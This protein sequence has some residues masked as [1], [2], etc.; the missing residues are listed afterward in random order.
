MSHINSSS[1]SSVYIIGEIGQNHNGSIHIA[2]SI[3]DVVHSVNSQLQR[4]TGDSSIIGFNSIKTTLRDLEYENTNSFNAKPYESVH[5]FGKTYLD[6]RKALEL[7]IDDHAIIAEYARS[8]D[9]D[10]VVTLCAPSCLN[11]LD[12]VTPAYLK[13]A[14]RDL[15]NIPLIR[16]LA[17]TKIPMIISTGMANIEDIDSALEA[18]THYHSSV[19]IL[20]C[21]S[22]YPP[23]INQTNLLSVPYLISHYGDN[24]SIGYSDHSIGVLLPSLAVA[25][26]ASIIE[27]HIT[28]SRSL[29][30]TDQ[31]G[32]L[33]EVGMFKMVRDIRTTESS[34]L[35]LI[36]I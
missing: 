2:Q 19:S 6:H 8:K 32:S 26:G 4:F 15:T 3:I 20:H 1:N 22:V 18:I 21:V 33:E 23:K 10:F 7:S 25:L 16:A 14:S 36:H 13:V 24:F 9:L 28:L 31:S 12:K 30:G 11:L 27:K 17:S 34:L 35:S 5:S 29:K